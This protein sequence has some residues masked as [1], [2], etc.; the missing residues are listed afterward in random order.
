MLNRKGVPCKGTIGRIMERVAVLADIHGNLPALEAVLAD[1][2]RAGVDLIVLNGDLADGPFPV[3]TLDLLSG[4][5]DRALW[6][7]GNEE[8]SDE[9]PLRDAQP[10]VSARRETAE[11]RV[12]QLILKAEVLRAL[13]KDQGMWPIR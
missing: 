13:R 7:R 5:G 2:E 1:V 12:K 4:L 6:L 3:E 9:H 10:L 11:K 8:S